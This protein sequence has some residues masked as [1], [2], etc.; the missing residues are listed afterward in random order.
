MLEIGCP[1]YPT[2]KEDDRG[3]EGGGG[4]GGV[5]GFGGR[6]NPSISL[7]CISFT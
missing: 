2:F 6:D 5:G 3:G 4:G 7:S 1:N